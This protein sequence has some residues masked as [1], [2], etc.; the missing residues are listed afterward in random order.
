MRELTSG[1]RRFDLDTS[2]RVT[3]VR[4]H[5]RSE[6]YAYD[7]AGNVIRATAP[8]HVTPG[9]RE[10]D[11]TLVRS[12]GRTSYAY[13]A[14]GRPIRR[15]RRLLNGQSRTW[16]EDRLTQVV[17][18]DGD[19]WAL[20]LR[21]ARPP[22]LQAPRVEGR[23]GSRPHGIPL[24]RLGP[25]RADRSGRTSHHLGLRAGQPS[26]GGPNR[27]PAARH[28]GQHLV[29]DPTGPGVGLRTRASVV[30]RGAEPTCPAPPPHSGR[31]PNSAKPNEVL[32]R[33]KH[34]GS[35]TAYAVYDDQGLP[36][37][38]VD[39]DPDSKPHGGVPAP[40]VLETTRNVNPKT[41]QTFL[42]WKK[43]PRHARPDELPQ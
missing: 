24:G 3:G 5:G 15:T 13:D 34:D 20:R 12:A 11:G 6:D 38:R 1:T 16:T 26:P 19:C 22:H 35:V 8:G 31:F 23:H 29:P 41:G 17:E 18:P 30:C 21:P 4:A 32:V 40:H 42:T 25:G 2:G 14:H 27:S 9:G 10:F 33:R 7:A 37:K 36:I 39:V 43:M 28:T